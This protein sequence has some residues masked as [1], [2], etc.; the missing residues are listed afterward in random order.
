MAFLK[1]V[2]D[3]TN[4]HTYTHT[5]AGRPAKAT[6]TIKIWLYMCMYEYSEMCLYHSWHRLFGHMCLYLCL[7]AVLIV[8]ALAINVPCAFIVR[9]QLRVVCTFRYANLNDL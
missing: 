9:L 8:F 6:T 7:H 2:Y 5:T 3:F 4:R 1:G